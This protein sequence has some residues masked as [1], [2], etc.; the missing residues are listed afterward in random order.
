MLVHDMEDEDRGLNTAS[1]NKG[2]TQTYKDVT[3]KPEL[4]SDQRAEFNRNV[5]GI[6]T[7]IL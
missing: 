5:K 1:R 6:C 7:H 2:G 3:I 4:P